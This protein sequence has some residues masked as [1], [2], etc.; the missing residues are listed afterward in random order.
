MAGD[1][2]VGTARQAAGAPRAGASRHRVMRGRARSCTRASCQPGWH[3]SSLYSQARTSVAP[4]PAPSSY[5]PGAARRPLKGQPPCGKTDTGTAA[6]RR[7]R[8]GVRRGSGSRAQRHVQSR[9][10]A[11]ARQATRS[12]SCPVGQTEEPAPPRAQTDRSEHHRPGAHGCPSAVTTVG[13]RPHDRA[14][15]PGA[16]ARHPAPRPAR[17]RVGQVRQPPSTWS[18]HTA[19]P[20]RSARHASADHVGAPV[21]A[22]AQHREGGLLPGPLGGQRSPSH[23]CVGAGQVGA[24]AGQA[25]AR[26]TAIRSRSGEPVRAGG[27]RPPRTPGCSAPSRRASARGVRAPG[28]GRAARPSARSRSRCG[29][30]SARAERVEA[31]VLGGASSPARLA[32]AFEEEYPASAGGEASRTAATRPVGPAPTTTASTR[33]STA[34]RALTGPGQDEREAVPVEFARESVTADTSASRSLRAVRAAGEQHRQAERV[35][36]ALA[37]HQGQQEERDG[38]HRPGERPVVVVRVVLQ[39]RTNR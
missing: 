37:Q 9:R 8:R 3:W 15:G 13:A 29:T 5:A 23:S 31:L 32:A 25:A 16:A 11:G 33:S 28:P 7:R 21:T 24:A 26:A 17:A 6:R 39:S 2:H 18:L 34:L 35:E 36:A 1:P 19:A 20:R 30:G 22:H 12:T 10:C 14:P 38:V 27:P 4:S